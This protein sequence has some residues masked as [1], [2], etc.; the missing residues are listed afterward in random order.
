M[1]VE[2]VKR[3]V[4]EMHVEELEEMLEREYLRKL[5]RYKLTDES[6]RKKFGMT[7]EDFERENIVAKKNYS[8]DVESDAQEWELAIDGIKT[9]QHKLEEL[10]R[11]H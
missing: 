10:R 5:T 8:W 11:G 6:F 2:A 4:E 9:C 7:Y 3:M 1:S